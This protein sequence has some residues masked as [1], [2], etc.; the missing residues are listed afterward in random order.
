[1]NRENRWVLHPSE[2][3][4]RRMTKIFK[5]EMITKRWDPSIDEAIVRAANNS[6]VCVR[7]GALMH[8]LR[9]LGISRLSLRRLH[10]TEKAKRAV[11]VQPLKHTGGTRSFR[12]YEDVLAL[13]RDEDDEVTS[14]DVFLHVHTKN[15]DGVT[16]I[17]NR[18]RRF[19]AELVRRREEHTQATPDRPIDE[20]QLYYNAARECSKG[21]VYGLGSLAKRKRRYEDPVPVR[22][23]S[24]WCGIQSLMQ[25]F[26]GLHNSRLS[27]RA[28]WE[29]AW[30]SEQAPFRHRR[31]QHRRH[32]F[33]SINSRL[34]WIW[35]VHHRSNTTMMM[36]TT[37][38]ELDEEYLGEES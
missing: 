19:H 14:N 28:S 8:E 3:C 20:K 30:T 5:R 13:D 35:L 22:P 23:G 17:D 29:C 6:K 16:F 7:Y 25:L 33:R 9:A 37:M 15:H 2:V 21:H 34:G 36:R 11:L 4:A 12:T 38:I 32:H 1:M 24:R 31:R 18:S 10:R 27:C 26:K